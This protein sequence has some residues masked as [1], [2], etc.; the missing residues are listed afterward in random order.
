MESKPTGSPITT[1]QIHTPNVGNPVNK[2][3]AESSSI[4]KGKA[5]PTILKKSPN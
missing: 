4:A 5:D 2:M 3:N 1:N